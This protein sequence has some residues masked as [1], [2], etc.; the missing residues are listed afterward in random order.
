VTSLLAAQE[1]FWMPG[2]ASGYHAMTQGYL[3]GEV[4]R[5][6]TGRSL[7]TVFR[8]EIAAPLGADFHI[9]LPPSED[10][11]VVELIPPTGPPPMGGAGDSELQVNVARN[12]ELDVQITRTLAWDSPSIPGSCRTRTR[13][14]GALRRLAGHHRHGRSHHH[15]LRHEQDVRHHDRRFPCLRP[16]DGLPGGIGGLDRLAFRADLRAD[17]AVRAGRLALQVMT[18]MVPAGSVRFDNVQAPRSS[19]EAS[20]AD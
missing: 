3:V 8:E 12:P 5:R 20:A 9:G 7:G 13:S 10:A 2:T 19:A 6:I 11:R 18:W 14:T 17:P 1:P 16:G 4:V 15:C